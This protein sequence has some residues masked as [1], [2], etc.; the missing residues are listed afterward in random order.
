MWHL[1]LQELTMDNDTPFRIFSHHL[2]LCL[3]SPFVTLGNHL[4]LSLFLAQHD[5]FV[6]HGSHTRLRMRI[7][8]ELQFLL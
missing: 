1:L 7:P 6:S 4:T 3:F 2:D 5:A 8:H